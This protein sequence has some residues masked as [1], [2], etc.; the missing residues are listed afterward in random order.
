MTV[1]EG[2]VADSRHEAGEGGDAVMAG[3]QGADGTELAL[4]DRRV[5]V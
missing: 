2:V 4:G 1:A 3:V 5:E